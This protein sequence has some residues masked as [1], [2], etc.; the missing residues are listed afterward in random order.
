MDIQHGHRR[1]PW[2]D[3][4]SVDVGMQYRHDM[5]LEHGHDMQLEHGH[6]MQLEHGHDMQ[7]EHGHVPWSWTC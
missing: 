2:I 1:S 5:Q 7:L 3:T 6:D 4:C